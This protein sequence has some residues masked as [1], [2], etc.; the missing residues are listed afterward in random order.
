MA[1][2]TRL[3][4]AKAIKPTKSQ[5]TKAAPA[6]AFMLSRI[7]NYRVNRLLF[8]LAL[9]EQEADSLS[10]RDEDDEALEERR[11][12]AV[13]KMEALEGKKVRINFPQLITGGACVSYCY[14][15]KILS[16]NVWPGP[17]VIQTRRE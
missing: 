9:V 1:R 13:E 8:E 14:C 10:G 7:S 11:R 3:A 2:A 5:V 15:F 17:F 12:T 6:D 16:G 4:K